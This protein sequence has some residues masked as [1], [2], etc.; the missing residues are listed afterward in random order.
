MKNKVRM[1]LVVAAIATGLTGCSKSDDVN[2]LSPASLKNVMEDN[3][4]SLNSAIRAITTT[5]VYDVFTMTDDGTSKSAV[6]EDYSV[7]ITMDTLKGVYEYN[8]DLTGY[9]NW[10]M[11]L[12]HYFN[13]TSD[14]SRMI[15]KMPL[16]KVTRPYLLRHPVPADTSLKNNFRVDVS[17]YHNNYNNYH[18]YDYLNSSIITI[19]EEEAG[20]LNIRSAVSPV[21]GSDYESKYEFTGGYRAEYRYLTGDSSIS[22]FTIFNNDD[23]LYGEKLIITRNDSMMFGHE[24]QYILTIGNMQIV[25]KHYDEVSIIVDGVVQKGATVSIIDRQQ[26]SETSV[27]RHRDIQITFEDGSV[28]LLSDLIS[29]SIDD[30]RTLYSSLHNVYFSAFIIDWLGYDIFY[31]R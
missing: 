29:D 11:P 19:D 27:C 16:N 9:V 24:R 14:N 5:K 2:V 28:V 7:H 30:I 26:D 4:V 31:K 13:R 3:A 17:D 15:I 6:A 1:L 10:N 22:S 8:N 21:T 18:D 25:R 12:I 20:K 23:F